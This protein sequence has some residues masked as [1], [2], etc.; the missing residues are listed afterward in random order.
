[1]ARQLAVLFLSCVALVSQALLFH[2]TKYV[3]DYMLAM[4]VISCAVAGVGL[5]AFLARR[6]TALTAH[7]FGWC[8]GGTAAC[9]Y[10]AA[11]VLLRWPNLFVLLPAIASVF[12]CPAYFI[13]RA[14]ALGA[15]RGIYFFDMLGAGVAVLITVAAYERFE[16]EQIF[17]GLVT[18]L[19]LAGGLTVAVASA[20]P[21]RRR[22]LTALLLLSLAALGAGLSYQHQLHRM[23]RITQL[24]NPAAPNIPAQS[25]LRRPSRLRVERTYDSLVGRLD[26]VP[27]TDRTYVTYDGFFN[28]NFKSRVPLDYARY[29]GPTGV[30]FPSVD[31]RLVYG[32]VAEP[33]VFVIGPATTGILKSLRA[34][35]P[36]ERI[37][38]VEINP[39]VLRMM[40]QDYFEASGRA[41]EGV[42]VTL[43]NAL[44]ALRRAGRK[45]DLITLINAHSS[46]WI[47]ALGPPDYLHTR[48]SYDLFLDH[49]TEEGYLLFEERPE[50]RRGELGLRRMILTLYDC[51]RRRGVRD[52][53]EHFFLWEFMSFRHDRERKKGIVPRND[54]YYVGMVVSLQ[55]LT[56]TRRQNLLDWCDLNM[57]VYWDERRQPVYAP[58]QRWLEPAY[59]Q[60]QWHNERFGPFFDMLASGDFSGLEET[61]DASPVTDDRPFASYATT[62]EPELWRLVCVAAGTCV[63]VGGLFVRSALQNVPSRRSIRLLLIYN[64][65][66]GS[67]YFFVEIVLL[68]AYQRV[69]VSPSAS[70][71]LVLGVLLI[72][73]A[74]GGLL[75]HRLPLIAATITLIPVLAA[76]LRL[77]DWTLRWQLDPWW[78][79]AAAMAMVGC[80]G[81]AMGVF[82]PGGLLLTESRSLREKIPHLFAINTL[83]GTFATVVS[84]YLG[85]RWG[86]SWTLVAAF[87]LYVVATLTYYRAARSTA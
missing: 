58:Y 3:L 80:V 19:P 38:A 12:V 77:P 78:T 5:G 41:Y 73:S 52:P 30:R 34:I 45:Y 14:F 68:Q 59:L 87:M 55:P 11:A 61:F 4:A 42:Q 85:L 29:A 24:V 71:V 13:A 26:T 67:G 83:S 65:A 69:F 9:L 17:L 39:G 49:L 74:V 79:G 27:G 15:A 46:R 62:H 44:P 28:D 53:A 70:L 63:L 1:M 8:C 6:G 7:T 23:M 21:R 72:S 36:L 51:L 75:A 60:G 56:G 57:W 33:R 40:L 81:I 10:A 32:L 47:G 50:T 22:A 18:V 25:L 31:R 66:I 43:G 20:E 82:F 2:A 86:Y 54:M 35:T 64:V 48:E 16:T 84:L 37:E 76:A